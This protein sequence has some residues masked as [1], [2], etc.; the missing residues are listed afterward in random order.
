M[1]ETGSLIY[2]ETL[3]AA[4]IVLDSARDRHSAI[5]QHFF[6]Y[7]IA[8]NTNRGILHGSRAKVFAVSFST[9]VFDNARIA[10]DCVTLGVN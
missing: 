4:P 7:D 1:K 3:V 6:R 5:T 2:D 9:D 8:M 10:L